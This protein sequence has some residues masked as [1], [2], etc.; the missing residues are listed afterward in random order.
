MSELTTIENL[1]REVVYFWYLNAREGKIGIKVFAES[2]PIEK[3]HE[4]G[5]TGTLLR[6]MLFSLRGGN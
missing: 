2:L 5:V 4:D 3:T 6:Q 1:G